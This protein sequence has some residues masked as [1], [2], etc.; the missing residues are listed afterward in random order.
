[1]V[2]EVSTPAIMEEWVTAMAA[3]SE[4]IFGILI[5]IPGVEDITIPTILVR[6]LSSIMVMELEEK[7]PTPSAA[8]EALTSITI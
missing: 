5:A 8:P 2:G 6:S 4:V 1:M 7:L 3:I